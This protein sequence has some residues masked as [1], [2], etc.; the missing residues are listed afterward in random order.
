MSNPEIVQALAVHP[1]LHGMTEHHLE[2]IAS[3]AQI[4]T[5][6]VGQ[7][8]GRERETA[9]AFYLLQTGRVAIEIHS[10]KKG[11]VRVLTIG[12]GEVVG[13]SWLVPPNRWQFD[14]RVVEPI[15]ALALDARGLRVR[16]EEDHELGYQLLKRLVDVVGGRLAA[17][18]LQLLDVYQ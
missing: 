9:S 5:V 3:C 2:Q 7:Y 11:T 16:C 4:I 1:F 17:T 8:L 6:T 10:P 15:Q 13:W 14:A 18:R 12:P